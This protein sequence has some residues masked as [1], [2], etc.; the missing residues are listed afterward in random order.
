MIPSID[1]AIR[2]WFYWAEREISGGLGF[3]DSYVM[4]MPGGGKSGPILPETIPPANLRPIHE[5]ISELPPEDWEVIV[6]RYGQP[7]NTLDQAN[8]LGVSKSKYDKRIHSAHCWINGYL[9][10]L[11][12]ER[13]AI[14]KNTLISYI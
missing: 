2:S 1:T 4:D 5:A 6:W 3:P 11:Q 9:R 7:G 8:R 12:R 14:D 10:S 13:K